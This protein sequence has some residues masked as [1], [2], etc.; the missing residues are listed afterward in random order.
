MKKYVCMLVIGTVVGLM[1]APASAVFIA[2]EFNS[3]DPAANAMT[4]I[5]SGIWSYAISGLDAGVRQE[6]KITDGTWDWTYPGPNSWYYADQDGEVT[7]IYNANVVEDGWGPAQH[8]LGLNVPL[9]WT[10]AGDMNDWNNADPTYAMTALGDGLYTLTMTLVPGEYWFKPVVMGTWDSLT[11]YER[12]VNTPNM[13][14]TTTEGFEVV[15]IYL[16]DLNGRVRLDVVPEPATMVLLGLGYGV[17]LSRRRR[18]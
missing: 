3:W 18:R 11:W 4:E 15:N 13:N 14:V 9:D 1:A 16:D 17:V 2:G 6:F 7:I 10:I 5:E 8:R 12:S